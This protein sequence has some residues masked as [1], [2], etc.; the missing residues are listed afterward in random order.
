MLVKEKYFL[1][2]LIM[3]K[4]FSFLFIL[5]FLKLSFVFADPLMNLTEKT[6]NGIN[7]M[8]GQFKQ[9][10][11][12][13]NVQ[14]GNFYLKKPH[15]SL[16]EYKG[17]EEK[18]LTNKFFLHIINQ[19]H[20]IIDS[21]PIGNNPI[22]YLL[23]ENLSLRSHFDLISHES[24]SYFILNLSEKGAVNNGEKATL[25]FDRE[26]LDLRKWEIINEYGEKTSLEFTNIIKN[27]SISA[28][29]FVI[30]YNNTNE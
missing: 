29:K 23:L 5:S 16:F 9:T 10:D 17:Q 1:I 11:N 7:S 22:K 30:H 19:K 12:D 18:I 2:K 27:I 8:T 28:D 14:F 4:F 13:G 24:D 25:Y 6:W 20:F 15:R 21:Y 26:T 3:I